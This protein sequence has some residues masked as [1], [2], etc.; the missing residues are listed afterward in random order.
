MK[1]LLV[2]DHTL[3]AKGLEIALSDHEDIE[4]FRIA[5]DVKNLE[6]YFTPEL[7]DV[8]LMDINLGKMYEQ[9]G[10]LLS[11]RLLMDHPSLNIVILSGYDLPLYRQEARRLGAK[12]FVNKDIAPE[13]LIRILRAVA[14]GKTRFPKESLTLEELT[15][16]EQKI[17]RL[18]SEGTK[19]KEIADMLF[20]SER[21]VSNHLQHTFDKLQVSSTVEAV[22]KAIKLGYLPPL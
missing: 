13:E 4:E 17:L 10:L 21:T 19:R 14:N 12:A 1:I 11:R 9:D 6:S 5:N 15:E 8:L 3:F 20:L 7:P 22:T 16:T 2:D 18:A